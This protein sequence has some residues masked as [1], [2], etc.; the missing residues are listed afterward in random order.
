MEPYTILLIDDSIELWRG[1]CMAFAAMRAKCT[2][3][4]AG[5]L[6]AGRALL[7]AEPPELFILDAQLPDGSGFDFYREMR[8]KSGFDPEGAR[9]DL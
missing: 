5:S 8:M 6:A 7:K 2:M 1:L 9:I 4:D 3:L